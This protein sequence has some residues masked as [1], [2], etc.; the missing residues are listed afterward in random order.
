M[1]L[2]KGITIECYEKIKESG[3]KSEGQRTINEYE[4]MLQQS[5]L[6]IRELIRVSKK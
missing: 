3:L 4:K 2:L 1:K 6:K 5:E